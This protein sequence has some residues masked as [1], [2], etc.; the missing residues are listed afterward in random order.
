MLRYSNSFYLCLTDPSMRSP[1][2]HVTDSPVS[3]SSVEPNTQAAFNVT[4]FYQL[5]NFTTNLRQLDGT[6]CH[7]GRAYFVKDR[8]SQFKSS[9][10]QKFLYGSRSNFLGIL[11]LPRSFNF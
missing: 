9:I 7:K 2:S 1:V 4:G 8:L 11:R 6:S 5:L 3:I 10:S